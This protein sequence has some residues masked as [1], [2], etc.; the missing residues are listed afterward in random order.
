MKFSGALPVPD[1]RYPRSAEGCREHRETSTMKQ[2]K[3]RKRNLRRKRKKRAEAAADTRATPPAP[4]I[5]KNEP[6]TSDTAHPQGAGDPVRDRRT[7]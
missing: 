7:R 5:G 3:Q 6:D 1:P 4:E 2:K